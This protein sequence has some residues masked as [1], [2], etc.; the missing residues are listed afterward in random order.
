MTNL[1]VAAKLVCTTSQL[2]LH[3][4]PKY[5]LLQCYLLVLRVDNHREVVHMDRMAMLG[6]CTFGQDCLVCMKVFRTCWA[7]TL[8]YD[9]SML[10][11]A[12]GFERWELKGDDI[13]SEGEG[14]SPNQC[15]RVQWSHCTGWRPLQRLPHP[16]GNFPLGDLAR[17][18]SLWVNLACQAT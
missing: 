14:C 16:R 15:A 3:N 11:G 7:L 2:R 18:T 10:Q 1:L 8:G 5:A 4:S 6:A 13:C 12:I 17:T 9:V